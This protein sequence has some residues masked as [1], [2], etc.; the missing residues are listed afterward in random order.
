MGNVAPLA[1]G[2]DLKGSGPAP[3]L[4][5]AAPDL[6]TLA[7]RQRANSPT[8]MS[9]NVLREGV[10]MPALAPAEM[11]IWGADFTMDQLGEAQV[12]LRISNL[13]TFSASHFRRNR[14]ICGLS[15]PYRYLLLA[16]K[17]RKTP[18][19]STRASRNPIMMPLIIGPTT[20]RGLA[21][22]S[23]NAC[24]GAAVLKSQPATVRSVYEC[25]RQPFIHAAR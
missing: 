17:R 10:V 1:T 14:A 18:A 7:R 5:R 16:K 6:T 19:I 21:P 13:A 11:P 4:F 23:A 25:L 12:A 20:P 15:S 3:Y 22:L 24:V 2:N 8:P 9:P